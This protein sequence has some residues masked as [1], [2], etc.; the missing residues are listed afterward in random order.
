ML[1]DFSK[2]LSLPENLSANLRDSKA[3]FVV[4]GANGWVGR[5]AL[6][7]LDAVLGDD[8]TSR[9]TVYGTNDRVLTLRSNRRV[10][11]RALESITEL[12]LRPRIFI[13]CAF[14][15]RDRV[16]GMKLEDYIAANQRIT[17]LVATAMTSCDA[18][19]LFMPSS[20]AVYRKGTHEVDEDMQAN[21]YGVLKTMDEQRFLEIAHK[22]DI[23]C[24][25][26]R[27]YNL[28]GPFI[29]K[30]ELY[31]LASMIKAALAGQ[32]ITIRATHRVVRSY[33]HVGDLMRLA[34]SMLLT[35]KDNS[36]PIFDTAG[37]EVVELSILAE[38][39]RDALELPHL[40][41]TRA[42]KKDGAAQPPDDIYVGKPGEM[43]RLTAQYGFPLRDLNTQ[44]LDTASY[45]MSLN[46]EAAA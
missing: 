41:I 45:L 46:E 17:D 6:E 7:M 19:G 38:R 44:I 27:L 15:T 11:C 26:P 13:H 8:I 25:I 29:N 40:P 39:I 1:P 35:S 23:P 33:I 12:S 43:A 5:C 34:F 22:L 3:D 21:P 24:C 14:L 37:D 16:A 42:T 2:S 9:V 30:V 10:P 18:R 20:G 32:P 4:T 31:A 36:A 28:A